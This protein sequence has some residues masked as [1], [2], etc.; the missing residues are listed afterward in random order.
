MASSESDVDGMPDIPLNLH[1]GKI[2]GEENNTSST[3][4]PG[5]SYRTRNRKISNLKTIVRTMTFWGFTIP[6]YGFYSNLHP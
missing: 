1:F 4:N 6:Q 3:R 5:L 2:G